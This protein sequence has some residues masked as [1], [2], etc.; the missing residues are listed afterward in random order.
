MYCACCKVEGRVSDSGEIIEAP[1]RR[2][3]NAKPPKDMAA[4]IKSIAL[5]CGV[6]PE[7]M[8]KSNRK[9]AGVMKARR[10]AILKLLERGLNYSQIG[11]AIGINRTSIT[12]FMNQLKASRMER[13][14]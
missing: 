2:G 1:R 3:A 7:E 5:K 12:Y 11:E 13:E 6:T 4:F 14:N 9:T 10:M 8:A